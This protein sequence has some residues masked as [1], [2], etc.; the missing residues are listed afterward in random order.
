MYVPSNCHRTE[1]DIP[2]AINSVFCT[3]LL[4]KPCVA[5]QPAFEH[6]PFGRILAVSRSSQR[7]RNHRPRC[8]P[9]KGNFG[10][11]KEAMVFVF[12]FAGTVWSCFGLGFPVVCPCAICS[13]LVVQ[14]ILAHLMAPKSEP[15][16]WEC[17]SRC[18]LLMDECRKAHKTNQRFAH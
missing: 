17:A 1:K 15:A 9:L 3:F 10:T 5:G 7:D 14:P 12:L 8:G 4:R 18:A 13:N 6:A 2:R 11:K 16:S